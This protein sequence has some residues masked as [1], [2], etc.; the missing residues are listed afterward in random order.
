MTQLL[1]LPLTRLTDSNG[2]IIPNGRLYSFLTESLTPAATYTTADLDVSHGSYVQA[3]SAGLLPPIYLDPAVTYRLQVRAS[4]YSDAMDGFDFDPVSVKNTS[5]ITFTPAGTGAVATTVQAKLRQ[6]V[7]LTDKGTVAD[8]KSALES[9]FTD[10]ANKGGHC[11]IPPGN[12]LL[13]ATAT[14]TGQRINLE[15]AAITAS[16]I[17]FDPASA[18]VALELNNPSSG[19]CFQSSIR[20]L[21]FSSTN[22]VD[23]TAIKFV[24]V[25]NCQIE[26]IGISQ[27]GW[28][29][30]NSI[31]IQTEGRQLVEINRATIGCA[32]PLVC[33]PNATHPALAVDH[34]LISNCELVGTSAAHPVIEFEDGV[35][36]AQTKIW[37]TGVIG[38]GDGIRWVNTTS[39]AAGFSL[40]IYNVRTE[41]GKDPAA[42]SIRLDSSSGSLQSMTIHGCRLDSARNG[43]YLR[44][45]LAVTLIDTMFNT[46]GKTAMDM[47][48]IPGSVLA[49]INCQG[50]GTFTF[51]NAR[52]VYRS[53]NSRA[54]GM[55]E[56]WVYDANSSSGAIQS[57]VPYGGVPFAVANDAT[58]VLTDDTFCGYVDLTTTEDSGAV[59]FLRGQT[60]TVAETNDVDGL[61]SVTKDNPSTLNVYWDA[62]SSAYLIQNKRGSSV[63][64]SAFKRGTNAG[65]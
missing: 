61:F 4:P 36:F 62:S 2:D 37:N 6:R 23:K 3:N 38:G 29:G 48:F 33:S 58:A 55:N 31:G 34:F 27:S 54:L 32:R 51:T 28:L 13:S 60:H 63:T 65:A 22:S 46:A 19:G 26:D 17:W 64:I 20:R 30:D 47:T 39:A 14:Y 1:A 42:Y 43:I 57:N 50:D 12:W 10:F 16:S 56:L 44:N 11:F 8:A 52:C 9:I 21:M 45:A 41:Q 24:N 35:S 53:A 40:D 49:I 18:D 59:F 7:D 5:D 15:G 25:A